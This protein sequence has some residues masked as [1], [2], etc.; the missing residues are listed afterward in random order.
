VDD[1]P[2]ASESKDAVQTVKDEQRK[3]FKLRDLGLSS[4][5]LGVPIERD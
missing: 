3:C 2:L 5:L 4:F 1:L